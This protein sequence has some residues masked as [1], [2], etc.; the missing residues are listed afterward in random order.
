MRIIVAICCLL[1]VQVSGQAQGYAFKVL[2]SKGQNEARPGGGDW[3]PLKIG[4]ALSENSEVKVPE[5]A[6][7][8]FIHA[9][10]KPLEIKAAGN[11]SVADLASKVNPGSG[12]IS[13][14]TDFILSSN[15]QKKMRL[16][17]TGAVHRDP[18]APIE[19]YLPGPG[20]D[21]V[22]S[23]DLTISWEEKKNMAPY[24][25]EFKNLYGDDLLTLH[26]VNGSVH[27]NLDSAKLASEETILITVISE[28]RNRSSSQRSIKKLSPDVKKDISG[29]LS[30]FGDVANGGNA[31][32]RY[33]LAGFYEE[34]GLIVDALSTYYEASA[35]AP[36]IEE[37]Q[38]AYDQFLQRLQLKK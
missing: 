33:I 30:D 36:D 4:E 22:Y 31:L 11:Y 9:S 10:G 15:E 28:S 17:A 1:L 34:H 18:P 13:K 32:D 19:L 16:A 26:S 25:I 5:N 20:I 29:I 27:V 14:Y 38:D 12:V 2:V 24:R 21:Q 35:M 6:Y 3:H 23:N 37:Y 8:A 7:I